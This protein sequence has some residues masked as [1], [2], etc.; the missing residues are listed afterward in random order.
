MKEFMTIW[1]YCAIYDIPMTP[2]EAVIID[3]MMRREADENDA[4]IIA[5]ERGTEYHVRYLDFFFRAAR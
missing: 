2:A 3:N 1:D 4:T 5:K